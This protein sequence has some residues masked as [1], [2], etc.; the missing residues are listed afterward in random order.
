MSVAR[1]DIRARIEALLSQKRLAVV[2]V[3]R[4]PE[5]V[6]GRVCYHRLQDVAP[7]VEGVLFMTSPAVAEQ[8]VRDSVDA[9]IHR[10]YVPGSRGSHEPER[11]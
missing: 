4:K 6:E 7:S 9:G 10:V 3:S 8:V 2:G 5:E 1:N 11:D